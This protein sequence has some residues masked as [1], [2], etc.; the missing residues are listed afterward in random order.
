[1]AVFV[2][3]GI[4]SAVPATLIL[5][6]VQDRLQAATATQPF[7]LGSYFFSAALSIP[8]WLKL[9]GRIGLARCWLLGMV[10]AVAVFACAA[11]LGSGDSAAFLLVCA[12]SGVAL[13]TD[14][15][16]PAALLAGTI[17]AS[18]DRG[19]AEG[20]YFGWW[21]FATKLNLALAAGV[22][23]PTLSWLGYTPGAQDA[24]ALRTLTWTYC[25]LPCA[26][27]LLAATLL[28]TLI[29]RRTP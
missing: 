24:A 17:A 29:I 3:N 22:A 19:R 15:T 4:A 10:L 1:L 16:L 18:G 20:A 7:F 8:L 25:L 23:L 9:V 26:L 2:V 11:Q 6:F 5:F 14:L 12:L 28:Y 27:K 13:G 21:N